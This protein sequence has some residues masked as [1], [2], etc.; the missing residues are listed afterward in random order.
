MKVFDLFSGIG[1]FSLGLERAGMETI[2]F[3]EIEKFCQKVLAKH[4]P[5]TPIASDIKNW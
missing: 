5:N 4:W 3:C 1:G 2:A